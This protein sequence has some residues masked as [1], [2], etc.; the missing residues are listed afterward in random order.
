MATKEM[1]TVKVPLFR[2]CRLDQEKALEARQG[3]Q[4][5]LGPVDKPMPTELDQSEATRPCKPWLAGCG[6][7]QGS[8]IDY[9][10]IRVEVHGIPK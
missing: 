10:A 5:I 7:P 1:G 2:P 8:P 3:P 9:P 6:V 4:S